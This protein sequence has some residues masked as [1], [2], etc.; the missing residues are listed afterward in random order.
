MRSTN[1]LEFI[2]ISVLTNHFV[3]NN[4]SIV[5]KIFNSLKSKNSYS[6]NNIKHFNYFFLNISYY[7]EEYRKISYT[8]YDCDFN[9]IDY[10]NQKIDTSKLVSI[11]EQ[12]SLSIGD[13]AYLKELAKS[14]SVNQYFDIIS[15]VQDDKLSQIC[16]RLV[17]EGLKHKPSDNWDILDYEEEYKLSRKK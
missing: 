1:K 8:Y 5:L 6:F 12:K 11:L 14:N 4:D 7:L 9:L 3:D 2:F 10:L 15:K 13:Y 17:K 16:D